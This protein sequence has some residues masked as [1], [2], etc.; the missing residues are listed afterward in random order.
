MEI[1]VHENTGNR[2]RLEFVG[3]THTLCNLLA[4][5]LW[6]DRGIVIAGYT[7]EHPIVSNSVLTVETGG[8]DAKKALLDAIGRLEKANKDFL[9]KFKSAAK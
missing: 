3:K 2:L 5:E 1:K 7:L 8:S 9:S 6:N 4:K